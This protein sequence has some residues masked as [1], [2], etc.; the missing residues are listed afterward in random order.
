MAQREH[1]GTRIGFLMAA[2]GSA[3][4]LG[5]LWRFPYTAGQNGGGAFILCYVLFT[6]LIALPL[7]MAELIVGRRA[8]R[9]SVFAYETLT[10]EGSNWKMLGWLNTI[11]CFIILG[12]YSVVSGWSL[13]YILMSLTG[14]TNGKSPAE[15]QAVFS[16]LAASPGINVFWLFIFIGLNV[17]IVFS[18]IRKGI[19]KWSKILMPALFVILISLFAYAATLEGFPKAVRFVFY[20]DFTQLT[21]SGI[22]NALG[23]AFFTASVGLGIILTY[24]SYMKSDEDIPK[25]SMTVLLMT[26]FVSMMAALIIFPIVFTYGFSPE[27]GPGLVFQT[28]PVIFSK[29]P[30]QVVLSTVFFSL[31]FFT[32][33]TSTI[34]LLEVLVANFMELFN[35]PREKSTIIC[36]AIAFVIGVPCA[37]TYSGTLFASWKSIYGM[38]FFDTM[39]YIT[40]SWMMPIAGLLTIIF[41]GWVLKKE[42]LKSEFLQGTK[43]PMVFTPWLF[44]IRWIAPLAVIIIILHETQIIHF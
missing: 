17:G 3:I 36:A 44:F 42:D 19:E 43:W 31:L 1:W 14:F 10:K 34:S 23:M 35:L 6:I 24:G 27:Q 25:T 13:S 41:V 22:L 15:I 8:Q 20:P 30:G 18:G 2:A 9:G 33:I 28:L 40:A 29:L 37:L 16:T 7:F 4:G 32:A 38:D 26:L 21:P 39:N 5:S 11:S 12:F